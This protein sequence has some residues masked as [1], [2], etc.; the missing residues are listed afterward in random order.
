MTIL[1]PVTTLSPSNRDILDD[2]GI[3]FSFVLTPFA[4][5]SAISQGDD[6]KFN[7][8]RSGKT[9]DSTRTKIRRAS[10]A[11]PTN[12]ALIAKCTHC[13]SPL[14]PMCRFIDQWRILCNI[15]RRT[16]DADFESQ[17][18]LRRRR[19]IPTAGQDKDQTTVS[20]EESEYRKRNGRVYSSN[21]NNI[22]HKE[23]WEMPLTEYSL[24]LLTISNPETQ[25][26][27]DE[28]FTL[29][30]N[31]CPPLLAVF[32]DGTSEEGGYYERIAKLLMDMLDDSSGDYKGTRMGIFVM[33]SGGGLSIYDFTNPGGHLKHLWID[34]C[35]LRLNSKFDNQDEWLS[36]NVAIDD[37]DFYNVAK[38]EHVMTAEQ[39]FAP[40]DGNGRVSVENALREIADWT[41]SIRQACQRGNHEHSG[42]VYLGRTL[43]YFLDF[44]GR[45]AYQPCDRQR[46]NHTH[47]Y[48]D[49]HSPVNDVSSEKF[50]YAGG[51]IFCFLSQAPH[52]VGN[53]KLSDTNGRAGLGGFGGGCAEIGKRFSVNVQEK[54]VMEDQGQIS[55]DIEMGGAETRAKSTLGVSRKSKR[56]ETMGL[57]PETRYLQ[58]D[59]YYQDIG[60]ASAMSAFAIEI[61]ALL[62]F[63]ED[64]DLLEANEPYIG[65]P[66]LRLLSDRSGG[67]GPILSILPK[68]S[69]NQKDKDHPNDLM[70]HEVIARS[71][72]KR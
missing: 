2:C 20:R 42:G 58:V 53:S 14:N 26:G 69:E 8:K 23:E 25:S 47:D 72:W 29:P 63:E 39:I 67:C 6:D 57:P 60:I 36:S 11:Y 34:Q 24:P 41:I 32:I 28:I 21:N 44:M 12:A 50:I 40:L 68:L 64:G 48:N 66:F 15:C 22:H 30:A 13:G 61:F 46:I 54:M 43:Q 38:L 33:T 55:Q 16:Y 10:D 9:R 18:K 17:S 1:R 59:E 71:P 7:Q 45:I 49:E 4:R 70:L 3:P 62:Q 56:N 37:D 31:L 19:K 27:E 65:I 5:R 35:P 51:K 52:E